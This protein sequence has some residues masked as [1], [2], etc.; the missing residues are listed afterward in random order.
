MSRKLVLAAIAAAT[1][2]VCGK[3]ASAQVAVRV[4][5]GRPVVSYYAP[6]VAY[7]QPVPVA[8]A[9]YYYAP[10]PA[11]VA[12]AGYAP[13]TA[14]YATPQ[15]IAIAP[16]PPVS[17]YYA[18]ASVVYPARFNYGLWGRLNVRTPYVHYRY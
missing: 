6:P 8:Q 7:M 10:G 4:G 18:P 5:F 11:Y 14:Y 3:P 13:A 15:P 2:V 17:Y 9:G 1:V 16:Q 12:P